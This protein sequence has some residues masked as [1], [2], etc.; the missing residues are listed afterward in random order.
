M[1]PVDSY[2]YTQYQRLNGLLIDE[3]V[4]TR[5]RHLL[6]AEAHLAILKGLV[7]HGSEAEGQAKAKEYILAT[8][9]EEYPSAN[10]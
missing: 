9:V 6:E 1:D 7:M 4:G 3:D 2:R 10:P 8:I 5:L